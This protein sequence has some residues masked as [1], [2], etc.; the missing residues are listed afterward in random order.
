MQLNPRDVERVR[1]YLAQALWLRPVEITGCLH[2][3]AVG[4]RRRIAAV[5]LWEVGAEVAAVA[6]VVRKPDGIVAVEIAEDLRCSDAVDRIVRQAILNRWH[7]A[8]RADNGYWTDATTRARLVPVEWTRV[9][10][11]KVVRDEEP[12]AEEE[13]RRGGP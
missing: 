10:A 5:C 9:V 11:N 8:V 6:A 2:A 13:E 7:A 3:L 1:R 12:V 4:E